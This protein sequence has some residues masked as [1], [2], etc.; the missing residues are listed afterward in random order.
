MAWK[1]FRWGRIR[2]GNLGHP[3]SSE[4]TP[5]E[6]YFVQK[7][8]HFDPT[9]TKTWN[10]RY[11][12]NDSFYQPNGPFFL[13]I[14]GEGEASPKWMVNGTW[15]DYA[16]K[17][18]AYCVMVEHR[19]YGKSHPTE[20]LGVK[21]LK[22]LSSEQALGDLAYFISSLNNK[23]NIF[24]PPKWIV[25]GGSYPGSLAAWMRLKYP[26]LVL[27]A[28]ST[29]G[30]L[31]ALINFEE[32]F[33]VVKDSLSSY[34]PECVTAI[35]AG[36][37]QI[38]SLLI[39]P[40]GQRSLFKMFKLCDPLELNNEDDNSNLFE[41]LAGNFAGVVQYNKDNRHDQNSG[42]SDLTIDYLCD[43]MLNQSLG[44]EI[45]RLAVVN[46][47]VLNKTTKE[48]CLDYKYDKMI[49]Q[50]QLTDWKSEVAEGGRQWT[51]QTCTEF[52][53]FQTSS[54]N[55]TKQMFGNKF[56]PEFFLKQCTD[57]FGIKYNAN[58]TEE[59]IIRTN[60]IYGGLNLVADNI[61]FVH[62]SIDPWHALGIT[63]TLRPGAPAIYIQGT[64]H[65]ANMY[66]S[67]EK[68]PPQLVDARKQIEQLIGE[69]LKE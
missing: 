1:N 15:L 59:G 63:K 43:I 17:Y 21:N 38:M 33:D 57:I 66:P 16:K 28:V 24:P 25:M 29:S 61:V 26:H 58:L 34:N 60:M 14:G 36:T 27:G 47:V 65:C 44:K 62:G 52:G 56:P 13:M 2:H 7:L 40:L 5:E 35:E 11:F 30:P 45:N 6:K 3:E 69:W 53:F 67:S 4:I 46:E 32:Y 23:L 49:K 68:D 50:M 19:F 51:Y 10:Q 22:Y 37:K 8:D 20:D 64:A 48:K 18:N 9:N 31:L 55:T 39:H 41:S 54:L 42:G 12:V